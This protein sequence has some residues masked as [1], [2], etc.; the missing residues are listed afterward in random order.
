[1][2]PENV[3]HASLDSLSGEPSV[4]A[5]RPSREDVLGTSRPLVGDCIANLCGDVRAA[6]VQA[7]EES[8]VLDGRS[9]KL[10]CSAPV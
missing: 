5:G 7:L 8:R 1:M 4:E 3:L 10:R 9:E 2:C 6:R